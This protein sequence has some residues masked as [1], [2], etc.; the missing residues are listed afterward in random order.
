MPGK[1]QS[2]RI[3]LLL[4]LV[5][6]F[7]CAATVIAAQSDPWLRPAAAPAP[8]DNM[9]TPARIELGRQLFFDPRL[10]RKGAMSCASC[11]NPALGWSDGLPTAAGFDMQ[12]LGRATPTI[13]NTA[14]N[15]IQMWD[16]RKANLEDQAL[17]PIAAEGEMNLPLPEMLARLRA[18]PGYQ[19]EFEKAYPGEGISEVTV[20]RAIASFERTVL[21]TESPFDRWRMGNEKAM[22][23]RAKRGFELFTGKAN[24]AICHMGYNFTDNG[25]HNIGVKGDAANYDVGRYAQR[26]LKAMRGAFKTPTLRDIALTGPYM[27]NGAYATLMEVVEHYDRGGDDQENLSVNIVPLRLTATEK[28]ELV[29]FMESL[30][31]APREISVPVLPR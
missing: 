3:S 13:L 30:T 4:V 21:S 11:H 18:I 8:A 28:G 19:P 7:C 29:A 10:S 25:F 20:A 16:G 1:T 24:C 6:A 15:T 5:L 31:G 14:F 26:P 17:G 9:P 2:W 12:K 23:D 22:S 27:R